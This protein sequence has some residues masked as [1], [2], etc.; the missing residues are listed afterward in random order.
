MFTGGGGCSPLPPP[1]PPPRRPNPRKG[2][3]PAS[4]PLVMADW[5]QPGQLVIAMG[6]DHAHKAELE[7]ECLR[8][9]DCYVPDR[10][11]QTAIAGELRAALDAGVIAADA[12][13]SELGD[14]IAGMARGRQSDEQLIICDLTGTGIQDTAIADLALGRLRSDGD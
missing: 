8:R 10:Q 5:L 9:A 13:F 6:S 14:V 7:P 3:G 2:M 12:K 11:S 4:T 1:G